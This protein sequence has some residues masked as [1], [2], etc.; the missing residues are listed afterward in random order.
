MAQSR[1][2]AQVDLMTAQFYSL[3]D[4]WAV[5]RGIVAGSQPELLTAVASASFLTLNSQSVFSGERVFTPASGELV[6]TDVGGNGTYT[7]GLANTTVVAGTY[8]DN[9]SGG[10]A[11]FVRVIVDAKGRVTSSST[12]NITTTGVPEGSNLYYTAERARDD[13]GASLRNGSGITI[14]ID[15]VSDTI[16][17][18]SSVTQYT[19]EMARDALGAALVNGSGINIAVDDVANTITISS[20]IT[21]YTDENARDAIGS[22]LVSTTGI[23]F[24]VDD[25]GDT[26]GFTV[27]PSEIEP[28][29]TEMWTGTSSSKIVTPKTIFDAAVTQDL[30]DGTTIT[31]DGNAGFN[32]RVTLGGSRTLANPVNMKTGQSG[33]IVIAQDATGSRTLT[34]G[35][36]WRFP[37]GA[38]VS[39]VLSTAANAVDVI[40]YYVRSDGSILA[41]L[42][43]DY[44]A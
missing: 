44:K 24:V 15:D 1:L 20:T 30:V 31:I 43:K 22:A 36:N 33:I 9:G 2:I 32:F 14:D 42:A 17:I 5:D 26:I 3:A 12:F 38:A 41:N 16:T 35:S 23:D 28:T 19:D 29:P 37:G 18:S 13:V 4:T 11:N 40:S 21:Q 34:Y 7:L 39:G 27:D 25:T 6:G 10:P 8:G